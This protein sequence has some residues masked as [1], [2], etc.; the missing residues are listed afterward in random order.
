MLLKSARKAR[1][2]TQGE[3][4][5]RMGL[6]RIGALQRLPVNAEPPDVRRIG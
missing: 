5:M 6:G 2:L 1:K 4:A 3:L